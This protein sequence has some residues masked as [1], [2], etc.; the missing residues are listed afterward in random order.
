MNTYDAYALYSPSKG[1]Y[2]SKIHSKSEILWRGLETVRL[3]TSLDHLDSTY[4]FIKGQTPDVVPV[5]ITLQHRNEVEYDVMYQRR[6]EFEAAKDEYADLLAQYDKDA[7]AMSEKSWQRFKKLR[8][9]KRE[10]EEHDHA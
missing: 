7:D 4:R 1:L 3:Y 5:I 6:N 10:L 9:I 2:Y 8:Q